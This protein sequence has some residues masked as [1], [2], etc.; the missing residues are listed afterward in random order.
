MAQ[1]EAV[2]QVSELEKKIQAIEAVLEEQMAL[3]AKQEE[4]I[5]I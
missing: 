3:I 4:T 2:L 5:K 1:V